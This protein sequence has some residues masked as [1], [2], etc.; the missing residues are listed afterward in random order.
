MI[1]LF[2]Q[3]SFVFTLIFA[4]GFSYYAYGKK[5]NFKRIYKV[6][7][8]RPC[9]RLTPHKKHLNF[10]ANY[11]VTIPEKFTHKGKSKTLSSSEYPEWKVENSQRTVAFLT[12]QKR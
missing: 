10:W 8:V 4:P 3:F 2:Q 9:P 11:E 5:P 12:K 6:L 7:A 1:K